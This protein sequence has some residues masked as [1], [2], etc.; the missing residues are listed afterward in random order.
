MPR[1]LGAILR[2][3]LEDPDH[4]IQ[5]LPDVITKITTRKRG[6]TEVSF[7]TDELTPGEVLSPGSMRKV[8]IV[9][10]VPRPIYEKE[11]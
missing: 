1:T 10:W 11:G 4:G 2:E 6:G 7:L 9:V 3:A 5:I 8:G